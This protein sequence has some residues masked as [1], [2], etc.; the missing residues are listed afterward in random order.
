MLAVIVDEM[1]D[2]LNEPTNNDTDEGPAFGMGYCNLQSATC[3][4]TR[5]RA[6]VSDAR[7]ILRKF[8]VQPVKHF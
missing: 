8:Q 4:V 2:K 6:F 5:N 3:N 7:S 1:M